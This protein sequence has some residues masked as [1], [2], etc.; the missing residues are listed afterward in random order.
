MLNNTLRNHIVIGI[1]D[2]DNLNSI[3]TGHLVR[4]LGV[5][6]LENNIFETRIITRHQLFVHKDIPF[7][8]HNSSASLTGQ[9]LGNI[10]DLSH[11]CEKFLTENAALGS[12]VGL[13]IINGSIEFKNELVDWG[14]RAKSIILTE[15][16]AYMLAQNAGIYLKGLTGRKTGVIGALAAVG[17]ALSGNDGRVLWMKNLR[18]TKGI[19]K[20]QDIREIIGIDVFMTENKFILNDNDEVELD[21]WNRPVIINNQTVLYVEPN[22]LRPHEYKTAPKHFIKSVSE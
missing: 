4:D 18:E 20:V 1:D 19:F 14:V 16:D 3:G 7:T 22:N 17:L 12:D 13:C 2:T 11:F 8:S 10:D 6:L 5:F 21:N 15:K 9:L